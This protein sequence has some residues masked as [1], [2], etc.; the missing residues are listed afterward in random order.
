MSAMGESGARIGARRVER[1]VGRLAE[2]MRDE[3][4][5]DVAVTREGGAVVLAG[6]RLRARSMDDPRLRGFAMLA[7]ELR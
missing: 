4:P 5:G 7:K 1:V 3:V 2:A 6:R